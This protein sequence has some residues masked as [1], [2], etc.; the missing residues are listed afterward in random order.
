MRIT[1]VRRTYLVLSGIKVRVQFIR[2]PPEALSCNDVWEGVVSNIAYAYLT[3]KNAARHIAS[4][5][6]HNSPRCTTTA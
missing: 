2:K 4:G 3:G 5:A 1:S 6:D